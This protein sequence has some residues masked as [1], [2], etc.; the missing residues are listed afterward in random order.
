MSCG[1]EGLVLA[2]KLQTELIGQLTNAR[3]NVLA[4]VDP[5]K[6]DE[7]KQITRMCEMPVKPVFVELGQAV[8]KSQIQNPADTYTPWFVLPPGYCENASGYLVY[9]APETRIW[10]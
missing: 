2:L 8:S 9:C 10:K 4:R 6:V 3:Y 7:L 5:E 1:L